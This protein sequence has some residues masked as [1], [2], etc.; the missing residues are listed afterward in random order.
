MWWKVFPKEQIKI[1]WY[2]DIKNDPKA[3]IKEMYQ[4]LGVDDSFV[5][6]RLENQFEFDYHKDDETMKMKLRDADRREWLNFYLPY[7]EELEKMTGKNLSH[8]KK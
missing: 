1:L 2:E 6:D 3:F 8:W 7:T 4:F 5:P